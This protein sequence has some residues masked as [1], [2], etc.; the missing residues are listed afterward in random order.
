M[1]FIGLDEPHEK[2]FAKF[3]DGQS[4]AYT[5][6]AYDISVHGRHYIDLHGSCTVRYWTYASETRR[7]LIRLVILKEYAPPAATANELELIFDDAEI[8]ALRVEGDPDGHGSRDH[9]LDD[10][11]AVEGLWVG[12]RDVIFETSSSIRC[13][14]ACS[15]IRLEKM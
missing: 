5:D 2:P 12:D 11:G 9:T 4:P 8:T 10:L 1:R 14:V 13:I 6:I 15:T 3:A 7:F